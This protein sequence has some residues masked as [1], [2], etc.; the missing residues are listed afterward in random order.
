MKIDN[1]LAYMIFKWFK[2]KILDLQKK[3]SLRKKFGPVQVG[4]LSGIRNIMKMPKQLGP[5][6]LQIT[7]LK[8]RFKNTLSI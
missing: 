5:I 3:T 8:P 2:S 7:V 6:Y 1:L 4:S